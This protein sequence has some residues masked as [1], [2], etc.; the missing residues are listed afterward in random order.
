MLTR[1]TLLY[2]SGLAICAAPALA[3]LPVPPARKL[4]FRI[5]R[6]GSEIG[7]HAL[8]FAQ[9]G[10]ALAVTVDVDMSVSLGPIRFFHYKHHTIESWSGDTFTSLDSKT[11][12]DGEA[13]FCTVRR[14]GDKLTV[15]GSKAAKYTA[16]GATLAA[17]HWNKAELNGPMINPENGMLVHPRIADLGMGQ[18]ALA[19]GTMVPAHHFSWRGADSLDLWYDAQNDWAGLKATVKDGSELT[20]EKT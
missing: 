2:T 13:A 18:V 15:E 19:S 1:R 11:D 20:Y 6:N 12:Y 10:D 4:A 16:P 8:T 3:A 5:L 14:D 17:T 9:N 7:T